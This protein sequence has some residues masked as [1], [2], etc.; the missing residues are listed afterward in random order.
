[1]FDMSLKRKGHNIDEFVVIACTG[2]CQND[3]SK[4]NQ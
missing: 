1:M 2:S 3:F 4:Y